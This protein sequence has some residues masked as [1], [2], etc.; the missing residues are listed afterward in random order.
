MTAVRRLV[1]QLESEVAG[2]VV[3]APEVAAAG[4]EE[5]VMIVEVEDGAD[6]EGGVA[7]LAVGGG[8]F[9]VEFGAKGQLLA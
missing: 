1:G 9:V 5:V 2:E 7:G 3:G 8:S 4:E 6:V